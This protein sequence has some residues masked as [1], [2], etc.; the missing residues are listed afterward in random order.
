MKYDAALEDI[1]ERIKPNLIVCFEKYKGMS[2]FS[3]ETGQAFWKE[4]YD[5]V[6][7]I[8]ATLGFDFRHLHNDGES[9][10][11]ADI[12]GISKEFSLPYQLEGGT[13]KGFSVTVKKQKSKRNESM[14]ES[15]TNVETT[16]E[17]DT[18]EVN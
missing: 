2:P 7:S 3:T 15:H 17:T 10:W 13:K 4:L 11:K 1:K 18:I 5:M 16:K 9:R 6:I 8:N 14:S 12:N